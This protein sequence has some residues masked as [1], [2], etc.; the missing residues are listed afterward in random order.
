MRSFDV[1]VYFRPF[2]TAKNELIV[3]AYGVSEFILKQII[4]QYHGPSYNLSI[5]IRKEEEHDG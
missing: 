1:C 5:N 2:D 4:E 3:T